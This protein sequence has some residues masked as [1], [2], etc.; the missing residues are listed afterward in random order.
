VFP[1]FCQSSA[2]RW[3]EQRSKLGWQF[4]GVPPGTCPVPAAPTDPT[5]ALYHSF[6]LALSHSLP[7]PLALV[8]TTNCSC[9]SSW[10][11]QAKNRLSTR[12]HIQ[13]ATP[14]SLRP[15]A[16]NMSYRWPGTLTLPFAPHVS[17]ERRTLKTR[18]GWLLTTSWHLPGNS[19]S[20]YCSHSGLSST[21]VSHTRLL[22][23]LLG[24][25]SGSYSY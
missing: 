4:V 16:R 10:T 5:H 8:G 9:R 15:P 13:I 2:C 17:L 12:Y 7:L 14:N 24:A 19:S 18:S 20:S 21:V 3:S 6:D 22:L 25:S 23:L 11:C 1:F